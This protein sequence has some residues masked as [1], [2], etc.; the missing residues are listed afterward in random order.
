[1]DQLIVALIVGVA[2]LYLLRRYTSKKKNPGCGCSGCDACGSASSQQSQ[3]APMGD[4][5]KKDSC[6]GCGH[7]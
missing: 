1:M 7:H 5:R 4:L 2:A 6:S 3:G